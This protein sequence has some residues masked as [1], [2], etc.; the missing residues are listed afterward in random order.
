[1]DVLRAANLCYMGYKQDRETEYQFCKR[2]SRS[3]ELAGCDVLCLSEDGLA[4]FMAV[5]AQTK[6]ATLVFRGTEEV[7]DVFT[8]IASWSVKSKVGPGRVRSGVQ[9]SLYNAW[10]AIVDAVFDKGVVSVSVFG[11]SLGGMLAELCCGWLATD[12]PSIVIGELVTFGS[13][14][15]GN[16][17]FAKGVSN[18]CKSV[19]H[20]AGVGDP[21]PFLL[22]SLIFGY[23]KTGPSVV[24]RK[25]GRV[26]ALNAPYGWL[27]GLVSILRHILLNEVSPHSIQEYIRRVSFNE[28]KYNGLCSWK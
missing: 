23:S 12:C 15:V 2:L 10:P 7:E 16:R 13:C 27:L 18:C 26:G 5:D 22:S 19:L 21:L 1:M 17:E 6:H 11:H 8:D 4:G 28:E 24:I 3:D 25:C 14:P 9:S 20:V